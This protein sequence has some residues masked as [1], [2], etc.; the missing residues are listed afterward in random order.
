MGAGVMGSGM[1]QVTAQ[2]RYKVMMMD[3]RQDLIKRAL[4]SIEKSLSKKVSKGSISEDNKHEILSNITI[5]RI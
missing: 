4:N 2:V 5:A 1:A 3:I